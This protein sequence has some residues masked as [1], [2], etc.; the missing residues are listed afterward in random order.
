MLVVDPVGRHPSC[1]E[2]S[3]MLAGGARPCFLAGVL[4]RRRSRP[5]ETAK[6][7]ALRPQPEGWQTAMN[8]TKQKDQ[9]AGTNVDPATLTPEKVVNAAKAKGKA[10]T[11]DQAKA[12]IE[13]A[14]KAKAEEDNLHKRYGIGSGFKDKRGNIAECDIVRGTRRSGDTVDIFREDGT[15]KFA[16]KMVVDIRCRDTKVIR[17]VA[18]SDLQ[19]TCRSEEAQKEYLK[20]F[21]KGKK[22]KRKSA[23]SQLEAAAQ[24]DDLLKAVA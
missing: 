12:L 10:I 4:G 6:A 11:L 18:T 1:G 7:R 20:Q 19:H 23:A 8:N 22:S 15:R 16:N 24:L 17:T 21:R 14:K 3:S 2:R 9:K 13:G 5:E